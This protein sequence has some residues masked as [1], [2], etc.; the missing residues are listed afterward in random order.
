MSSSK[1]DSIPA[2]LCEL[3][4][5][6]IWRTVSL[7][8][9]SSLCRAAVSAFTAAFGTILFLPKGTQC[10]PHSGFPSRVEIADYTRSQSNVNPVT[11]WRSARPVSWGRTWGA[12]QGG[13][14][15]HETDRGAC[16]GWHAVVR[17]DP[18]PAGNELDEASG[19]S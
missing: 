18:Q 9:C 11:F 5:A 12:G 16:C 2:T 19:G 10:Q 1:H 7:L 13:R 3:R 6:T 15:A 17:P 8:R 4:Y 14:G